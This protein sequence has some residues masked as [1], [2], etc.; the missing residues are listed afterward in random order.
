MLE[1]SRRPERRKYYLSISVIESFPA[2][3]NIQITCQGCKE[4][5]PLGAMDRLA[6][7]NTYHLMRM[8]WVG[9]SWALM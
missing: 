3:R 5:W 2:S 7:R 8:S 1:T 9:S 4:D 6:F